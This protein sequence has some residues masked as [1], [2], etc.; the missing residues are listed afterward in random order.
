MSMLDAPEYKSDH[1][2]NREEEVGLVTK[3]AESLARQ[4]RL[5]ERAFLFT[6]QRGS[7]KTW[8][9]QHLS[10][11]LSSEWQ[12]EAQVALIDLYKLHKVSEP[13]DFVREVMLE[14]AS[15]TRAQAGQVSYAEKASVPLER[16]AEWLVHDVRQMAVQ[17]RFLTLLLDSVYE[18]DWDCLELLEDALLGPLVVEPNVLV[19]MAGQG[20]PFPWRVPEFWVY[21]KAQELQHFNE[22]QVQEM[23]QKIG[24]DGEKA[25][26]IFQLSGGYPFVAWMLSQHAVAEYQDALEVALDYMLPEN[27]ADLRDDLDALCVL[28]AF[29]E[30]RIVDFTACDYS[31]AAR[32]LNRLVGPKLAWY[33]QASRGYVLDKAIR[34]VLVQ[35]LKIKDPHRWQELHE[36]AQSLYEEWAAQY[37][38]EWKTEAEY[39]AER[40]KEV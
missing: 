26:R 34:Q 32:I 30:D 16:W 27:V 3:T 21:G 40:L 6:G 13:R 1:F 7:G 19:V 31:E 22:T 37:G 38:V 14:F 9:L 15:Q 4:E 39:H 5:K 2:V 8:L 25:K 23:L 10:D 11:V 12:T 28:D 18:S 24:G 33:E 20:K 36:K 35:L 29:D 17:S